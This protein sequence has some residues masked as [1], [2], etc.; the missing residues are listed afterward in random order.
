MCQALNSAKNSGKNRVFDAMLNQALKNTDQ[1]KTR[2]ACL[3]NSILHPD[4]QAV[5]KIQ[6]QNQ[7]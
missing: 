4:M 7:P 3:I 6:Q 2:K 1:N 5:W